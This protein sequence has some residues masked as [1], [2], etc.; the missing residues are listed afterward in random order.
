MF[1]WTMKLP[2]PRS[3]DSAAA[4]A[5]GAGG[6]PAADDRLA[7]LTASLAERLRAVCRDWEAAEFD[8]LVDRIARTKLRWTDRGLGD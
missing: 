5:S 3:S 1:A 8:A 4:H 2:V 7:V 6:A